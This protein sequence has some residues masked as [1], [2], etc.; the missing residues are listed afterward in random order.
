MSYEHSPHKRRESSSSSIDLEKEFHCPD[1]VVD[2]V[3]LWDTSADK[4]AL[5]YFESEF[6]DTRCLERDFGIQ[7]FWDVNRSLSVTCNRVNRQSLSDISP[8]RRHPSVLPEVE[9]V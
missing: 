4:S 1:Q 3:F 7:P 8:E 9:G 6:L 2:E 5:Q